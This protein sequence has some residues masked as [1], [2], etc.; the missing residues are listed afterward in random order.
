MLIFLG[1]RMCNSL[2]DE[3]PIFVFSFIK[4]GENVISFSYETERGFFSFLLLKE[5]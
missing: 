3:M 2:A 1:E 4:G 5:L